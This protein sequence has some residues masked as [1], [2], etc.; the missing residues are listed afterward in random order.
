MCAKNVQSSRTHLNQKRGYH[1]NN[2]VR[3]YWRDHALL[4]R[5][6][7]F[8]D[9]YETDTA[10]FRQGCRDGDLR[11]RVFLVHGAAL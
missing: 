11:G 8:R 1:A 5:A 2:D 4:F 3:S 10:P 9:R 6:G 7:D